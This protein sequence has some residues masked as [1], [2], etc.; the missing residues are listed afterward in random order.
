M[1]QKKDIEKILNDYKEGTCTPDERAFVESWYLSYQDSPAH[2]ISETERLTD[3]DEVWN[4]LSS[5]QRKKKISIWPRIAAAAIL[6]IS[7]SLGLYFYNKQ[8]SNSQE[9]IAHDI[10]PGRNKAILILAN[11]TKINLNDAV[12]GELIT[13][14]GIRVT[15]TADG[16][17]VYDASS[18]TS[19]KTALNTIEV[20]VGGQWQVKLPDG[21]FVFLNASSTLT[22]PTRFIGNERKVSLKGEAYFEIAHN[23]AMPFKVESQGQVVEVLGTHFNIMAYENEP[24]KTTLVE[25]SVKIWGANTAKLLQPGQQALLTGQDLTV[26]TADIEEALAWKNGY[27]KF[28][29]NLKNIMKKIS[30][31]YDIEIV[32]IDE[33]DQNMEF[34][35]EI[36]RNKDLTSALEIMEMSGKVHF[37]I[38]KRRVIVM[39]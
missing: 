36:S 18:A 26:K 13:Q 31:W 38:E 32:Y 23:S 19:P 1:M 25:G 16:K 21:S 30:R 20:P 33:V 29:E 22:Y 3:L 39:P 4:N 9:L 37:K 28:S 34:G 6:V 14:A 27:F 12:N 17:I 5:I 2:E 10:K 35:G 24:Y 15:K 7:V 8:K 11:G